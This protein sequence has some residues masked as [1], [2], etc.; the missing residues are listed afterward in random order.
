VDGYRHLSLL[1]RKNACH[2]PKI[3]ALRTSLVV[4]FPV[5]LLGGLILFGAIVVKD[6]VNDRRHQRMMRRQQLQMEQQR[7]LQKRAFA[8]R[9]EIL[10]VHRI[11]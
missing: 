6:H 10:H 9:P 4:G 7:T 8:E 2:S 3:W 5:V 1:P 11:D